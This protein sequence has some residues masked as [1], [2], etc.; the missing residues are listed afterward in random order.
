MKT[1]D[2]LRK[3]AEVKRNTKGNRYFS[4]AD[5]DSYKLWFLQE[6]TEDA[7]N[8]EDEVGT[9]ELMEVVTSP[10]DFKKSAQAT[11]S[12]E[13]F[14]GDSWTVAKEAIDRGWRPKTHLLINIA[15]QNDDGVWEARVLDQ[16]PN[17]SAHVG[18]EMIEYADAYGTLLD[19]PYRI[20]RKGKGPDTQYQLIPLPEEDKPEGLEKVDLHELS[21]HYPLVPPDQQEA[22]YLGLNEG[23]ETDEKGW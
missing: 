16:K 17:A 23:S 21:D 22:F 4:L 8:F 10:A 5:G 6:L 18:S 2:E 1:L 13:Q 12:L 11:Q 14:G 3:K 15:V 7:A 19:R 20:S 9:A